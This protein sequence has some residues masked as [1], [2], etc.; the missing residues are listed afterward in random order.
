MVNQFNKSKVQSYAEFT[1]KI[2]S[3]LQ[4]ED[5]EE[6]IN[7]FAPTDGKVLFNN[8]IKQMQVFDV[9][10]VSLSKVE[11]VENI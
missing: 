2:W 9:S 7:K 3:D 6:A 1:I 4:A 8:G 11:K 10:E 5:L